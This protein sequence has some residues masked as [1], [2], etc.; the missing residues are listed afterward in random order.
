[1][2]DVEL[3]QVINKILTNANIKKYEFITVEHLLLALLD[4][5]EI[6]TFLERK[7]VNVDNFRIEIEEYIEKNVQVINKKGY[8]TVPT[9][10]FQRVLQRSIFQAQ[11]NKIKQLGA[12]HVLHSIFTEN[13][14]HALYL[15]EKNNISKA[16]ISKE[17]TN[18]TP[19]KTEE[20]AKEKSESKTLKWTT[21]LNTLAKEGKID[22]L[23]GR[24]KELKQTMQTLMRRRKN[25]P[26]FVGDAGVGK[27]ALA[28]GLAFNIVHAKV[29]KVLENATIYN[30]DVGDLIA[31][32][33]Y[34][35][36]FEDRLKKV[37]E[38]V[39]KDENSILFIDEIH[40]LIGAGATGGGSMDAANLLKPAL[41]DGSLRCMG[42][43][44]I[45]E[46]R[47]IFNKD[48]ALSRRFKKIDVEEPS[49]VDT[50]RILL[51]LKSHYQAHHNVKYTDDAIDTAIELAN[52]YITDK[53]FPDKA[54]DILDEVGSL[55]QLR[56]KSTRKTLI[57]SVDI[58]D[59]V[60]N[61]TGITNTLIETKDKHALKHLSDNLK[62]AIFGQ[63][64]A[65]LSITNA[66]KLAKSGLTEENKPIGSFL[67]A[68][69]T[70]VG[71]TE[72]C[73][74]LSYLLGIH[75]IRF[76]MSEYMDRH[77]SS[78]LIGSPPGYVGYEEGG[79]LTEA[80]YKKPYSVVLL[81]E[82]EKAH[83][84]IFNM[85]LQ[86]MDNGKLTDSN[87]REV[88]FSNVVLIMTSNVGAA[89]MQKAMI[90]FNPSAEKHS[91]KEDLHKTFTPEFRNRLSKIVYFNPLEK[92]HIYQVI[93][94]AMF[95]LEEKLSKN[96]ISISIDNKARDYLLEHGYDANMGA[97]PMKRL[98]E[99][100][101]SMVLA[102]DILFGVLADGGS[103]CVTT[104]Q[105]A[106]HFSYA[107]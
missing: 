10:G 72:L 11:T 98:I 94:K 89:T 78:K 55:Q 100:Q 63:D 81:D 5:E 104:K 73:K 91:Y 48:S 38:Y 65:I 51:G 3:Q 50:K 82:I 22:P 56:P 33:K 79:L 41:A 87:G 19:E 27:T 37:L 88:D 47:K 24:A 25:N 42:S 45:G 71:K 74:Q 64:E 28:H 39:K 40:T 101:I 59:I 75:L 62:Y 46:Y 54:I 97:R 57:K 34:R 30:L 69:P 86:I 15:L 106:L 66:I 90:G 32:T 16:D 2:L 53:K 68:G 21:N 58:E 49:L 84:D 36:E 43:T 1:M 61:I 102:D 35:G 103:V 20:K 13:E 4:I 107:E 52:R 7:Q 8:I 23:I 9:Q 99:E 44:T 6:A 93:D 17:L 92:E 14:S 76:D 77:S 85:F 80:V 31:G 26:I 95:T 96:N 67:F 83:P 18:H 70:G 105:N 29:P 60:A 12:F